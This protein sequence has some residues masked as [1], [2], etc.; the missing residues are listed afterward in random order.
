MQTTVFNQAQLELLRMM[1]FVKTKESM[2]DLKTIIAQYFAQK[3]KQ[4][5]V[6]MWESGEMNDE[7]FNHFKSL[8]ERTPY[9]KS[10]HA[11]HSA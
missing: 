10:K 6:K 3:A 7:K 9:R 8:H 4:E 11:E 2:D 1:S 5:M